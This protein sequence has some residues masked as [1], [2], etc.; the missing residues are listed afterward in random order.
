MKLKA[1]PK[2]TFLKR[3]T[4]LTFVSTELNLMLLTSL[5]TEGTNIFYLTPKTSLED[6]KYKIKFTSTSTI[7]GKIFGTK[8]SN[9]V[10]LERKRKVWYLFLR[11]F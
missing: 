2:S 6:V 8:W 11:V 4:K 10:K 5:E 9:P 3:I 1:L 7:P